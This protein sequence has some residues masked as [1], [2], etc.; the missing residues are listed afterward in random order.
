MEWSISIF[1]STVYVCAFVKN[2]V[3]DIKIVEETEITVS[4]FETTEKILTLLGLQSYR[5]MEKKRTSYT[6]N[7]IHIEIEEC[8]HIPVYAEFEGTQKT[9]PPLVEELGYSM[10]ETTNMT[11]GEIYKQY[12]LDPMYQTFEKEKLLPW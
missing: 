10:D 4:D 7:G 3:H 11:N 5:Y 8:P 2:E 12:G 9:I 6:L 1:I